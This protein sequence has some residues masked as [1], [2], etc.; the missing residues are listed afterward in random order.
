MNNKMVTMKKYILFIV[1]IFGLVTMI[2]AQKQESKNVLI[3]FKNTSWLPKNFTFVSYSPGE[4]GNNTQ[5]YFILP[6]FKRSISY[7]PGTKVYLVD[8]EQVNTV[9]SGQRID[10]QKP[11][12][13]VQS[14]DQDKIYKIK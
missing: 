12:L 9:M 14:A 5:G 11:F 10:T 1:L 6:G 7:K 3:Y 4:I 13:I 8:K 2:N